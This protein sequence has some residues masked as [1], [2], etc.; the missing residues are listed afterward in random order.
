MTGVWIFILILLNMRMLKR[1]KSYVNLFIVFIIVLVV[2]Y[3]RGSA[4]G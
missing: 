2:N 4:V 3:S 1:L